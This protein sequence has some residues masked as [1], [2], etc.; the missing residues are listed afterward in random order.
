MGN[1]FGNIFRLTTFGESHGEAIGGVIDGMPAGVTVDCAALR[2]AMSRRR[3]GQNRL[4]TRRNEPDG[5]AFL[6]GVL[7]G[8]TLGTP[9]AFMIRNTDA[10]PADYVQEKSI[11][12][13]SHADYTWHAKYHGIRDCR[14]G[15]R[16]S[17]RET[18]ARVAAGE[19][20]RQ[21][22]VQSLP[23]IS[24]VAWT[25]SI[26][27]VAT[28]VTPA[29]RHEV[30]ASEV[31]CPDAD[32]SRLMAEYIVQARHRGDTLGGIV[33]ATVR[34]CPAGLG[35][36]VFDKMQSRLAAAM[37]SIPAAKGFEYGM[38]FDGA[39]RTGWEM[40]DI[41]APGAEAA[42]PRFL[43]NH[44]GGLQGGITN[45]EEIGF[46]VAFKPVATLMREMPTVDTDG[47]PAVIRPQGRH[48]VCVVP[49]AVPVVEAMTWLVLA[50]AYLAARLD[51]L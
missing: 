39:R 38:G 12:R 40:A 44:S 32:A 48:D 7:D 10:R 36:P 42:R 16:A 29:D 28:G 17:A 19:L 33:S 13:P 2:A 37:M 24:V 22:L 23:D 47:N 25:K 15:G 31:R 14:G 11:F 41:M 26:G 43:S 20:A 34:G 4:T 1:S 51:C 46:S 30:E 50:D 6:S 5:V 3:P 49:R 45:G 9:I 35:A 8:V 21:M 18:A 27:S